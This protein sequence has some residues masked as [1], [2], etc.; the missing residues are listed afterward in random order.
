MRT[1]PHPEL[2]TIAHLL[3]AASSEG[4]PDAL[5]LLLDDPGAPDELVLALRPLAPGRHPCDELQDV[6]A[7]SACWAVGLVVHGRAHLLDAADRPP[8]PIVT[9]Y[10]VDREGAEVS[11]LRGAGRVAELPGPSLGRLPD[12]CR[13]ILGPPAGRA[14]GAAP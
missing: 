7:P 9:T 2:R 14:T 1:R 3:D 10:L 12:L 8:Q 5:V 6:S 13:R 4:A 11:L